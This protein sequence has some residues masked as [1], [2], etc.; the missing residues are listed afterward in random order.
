MTK[1]PPPTSISDY[2]IGSNRHLKI[3]CFQLQ[4]AE[5]E[6]RS[7]KRALRWLK[8]LSSNRESAWA[9]R[10]TMALQ[11]FGYDSDE[12]ELWQIPEVCQFMQDL[13]RKWK[14][15]FFFASHE[16]PTLSVLEACILGAEQVSPGVQKVDTAKSQRYFAECAEAM[17]RL[18]ERFD[19]PWEE[20]DRIGA[21]I[22]KVYQDRATRQ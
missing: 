17:N 14:Y 10:N 5:I 18:F 11:V 16:V 4:R 13:H 8:G 15:W 12:R 1:N 6:R 19:F 7:T 21:G 3:L 9:N 20:N 22:M 2:F